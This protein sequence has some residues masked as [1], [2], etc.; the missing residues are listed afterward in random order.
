MTTEN[1]KT[2]IAEKFLTDD[3]SYADGTILMFGGTSEVTIANKYSHKIAGVVCS[4][5]AYLNNSGLSGDTIKVCVNGT[6]NVKVL[7]S[8]SK[9]DIIVSGEN[10][11]GLSDNSDKVPTGCAVGKALESFTG[12]GSTIGTIRV[13]VDKS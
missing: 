9:G 12:D 4:D 6:T 10:G 13:S 2:G 7:H 3:T 8:V 5:P 1:T 11:L